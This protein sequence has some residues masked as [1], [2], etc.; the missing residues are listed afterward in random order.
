MIMLMSFWE[1]RW[2]HNW[3]RVHH[4]S[5]KMTTKAV[6]KR[7]NASKSRKGLTTTRQGSP[8]SDKMQASTSLSRLAV[9]STYCIT[10]NIGASEGFNV[11][12]AQEE[13]HL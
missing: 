12:F 3:H 5:H 9:K 4:H 1:A 11:V 13:T 6:Q 7:L 10:A 8:V 2:E